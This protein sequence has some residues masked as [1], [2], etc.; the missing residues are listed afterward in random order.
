M[1]VKTLSYPVVWRV[2][3]AAAAFYW[4]SLWNVLRIDWATNSQYGFGWSVPAIAICFLI[5]RWPHRPQASFI[6]NRQVRVVSVLLFGVGMLQ[7]PLRWLAEANPEWRALFW[8]REVQAIILTLGLL[9][10]AGGWGWVRHFWFPVLFTATAVPWS[11]VIEVPL[12]QKMMSMVTAMATEGLFWLHIPALQKGNVV[13]LTN[14]T[15]GIAEA[16]SGVRSLEASLMLALVAGEIWHLSAI[17]RWVVVFLGILSAFVL[18]TVRAFSLATLAGTQGFAAMKRWHDSLGII[19]TVVGV[20]AVFGIAW[21]LRSKGTGTL[22]ARTEK[23]SG[24]KAEALPMGGQSLLRLALSMIGIWLTAEATTQAWFNMH[25]T[26]VEPQWTVMMP[27][28]ESPGFAQLENVKVP[29]DE[30][31]QL[32]TNDGLSFRWKQN[33]GLAWNVSFLRWPAGRS[34][35]ACVTAHRP[36]LCLPAVGYE[37]VRENALVKLVVNGIPMLFHHYSFQDSGRPVQVFFMLSDLHTAGCEALESD[38]SM[39]GRV[40]AAIAG[41]R[42]DRRAILELLATGRDSETNVIQSL[43]EVL[44]KIVSPLSVPQKQL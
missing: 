31:A 24:L 18:N 8:C 6:P 43:S 39:G 33:G 26:A 17:R 36:D 34:S 3:L 7:F 40:R 21:C 10:L 1:S 37:F 38:L 22:E 41:R 27:S 2:A 13:Q 20:A 32:R 19:E 12:T 11:K 16:C 9:A 42:N 23:I 25:E 14:G 4:V 44:G 28:P 29:E 5:E 35:E 15:V 30:R